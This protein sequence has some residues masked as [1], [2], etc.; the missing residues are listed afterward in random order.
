V[1]NYNR[2]KRNKFCEI[3]R[4]QS[5][6]FS[7]EMLEKKDYKKGLRVRKGKVERNWRRIYSIL[8]YLRGT[9]YDCCPPSPHCSPP[10]G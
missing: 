4:F 2:K 6:K 3:E 8:F 5:K 1:L 10:R 9:V 7:E